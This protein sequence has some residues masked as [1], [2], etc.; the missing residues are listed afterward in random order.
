M[1]VLLRARPRLIL[2][3]VI[4]P[5]ALYLA[6]C[7]AM[8]S[9]SASSYSPPSSNLHDDANAADVQNTAATTAHVAV[10]AI[11]NMSY[12]SVIGSSA[13]P[14]LNSL[15]AQYG[16]ATQYYANTHPSIGNYFM[17]TTGQIITN[18]DGFTGTV[19]AD[20]VVRELVGAG[21][22]WKSYAESLPSVG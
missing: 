4:V 16:L 18:D 13:A 3:A 21:K 19:S 14:Y 6:G 8:T 2:I 15:A 12:E 10:V 9:P 1:S 17:L 5:A 7:G 20:N 22:S 11:E